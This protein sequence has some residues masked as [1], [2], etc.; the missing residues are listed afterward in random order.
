MTEQELKC[1]FFDRLNSCYP[2]TH[3]DYPDSVYWFYDEKFVR[4]IK[5]CRLSGTSLTLP[6]KVIGKCLFEQDW[7]NK[8]IWMDHVDIWSFFQSVTS[9][10]YQETK[11][12][13]HTW[14]KEHDKLKI[15]TN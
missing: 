9:Y 3:S 8:Y 2:V 6:D 15:L 10:N 12:L 7:E 11:Q 5:L 13:I 14:L 1:W 4:K